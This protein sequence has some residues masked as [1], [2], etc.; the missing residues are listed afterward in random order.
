[1]SVVQNMY[2]SFQLSTKL[3]NA[4]ELESYSQLG[5]AFNLSRDNQIF[6]PRLFSSAFKVYDLTYAWTAS[7][8]A[9]FRNL[10]CLYLLTEDNIFA[11]RRIMEE[12][13]FTFSL[14]L[15]FCQNNIEIL[16]SH[17]ADLLYFVSP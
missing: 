15:L 11:A 7:K 10:C 8:A 16:N 17:S 9:W 6:F 12:L 1:M 3:K 2:P 4:S 13:I 5:L 14:L